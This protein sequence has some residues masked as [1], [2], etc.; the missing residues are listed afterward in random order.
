MTTVDW[1]SF[2]SCN[3]TFPFNGVVSDNDGAGPIQQGD[4]VTVVKITGFD[5]KY[6]VI[7]GIKIG[8]RVIHFPI[9]DIEV[10]DKTSPNNKPLD[11]YG[12]WFCNRHW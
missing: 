4:K 9:I 2:L 11:D 7:A 6:G 8:R 3:L 12:T 5:D 10:A 1:E